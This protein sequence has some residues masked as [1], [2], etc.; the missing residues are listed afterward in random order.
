MT[1]IDMRRS[2]L[3]KKPL[4]EQ[5]TGTQTGVNWVLPAKRGAPA[6]VARN[7]GIGEFFSANF[8]NPTDPDPYTYYQSEG[9]ENVKES[10]RKN[11]EAA[12]VS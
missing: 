2:F 11:M 7:E 1:L 6:A 12:S 5:G 10:R 3:K 9:G 8:V 4:I